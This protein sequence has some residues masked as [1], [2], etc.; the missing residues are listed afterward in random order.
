M[1]RLPPIPSARK[2]RVVGTKRRGKRPARD[3]TELTAEQWWDALFDMRRARGD[4]SMEHDRGRYKKHIKPVVD[5]HLQYVTRENCEQL[6]DHLDRQ[7]Q[8]GTM[9]WKSAKNVWAVWTTACRLACTSN[10]HVLR[11]R[12]DN[13]CSGVEAPDKG[14][15][16]SKTWLWPEEFLQLV[17]CEEVPLRWRCIYTLAIYLY[18]RGS[19][20]AA[21]R[22]GDIDWHHGI[23]HVHRSF[24]ENGK[25]KSTKSGDARRFRVETELLPLLHAMQR[26]SGGEGPLID[27]PRREFWARRL[28]EHLKLAGVTRTELFT[29]DATREHLTFH[30]LKAT[31]VTWMAIRGD[32]PLKIMQ[33][34]AHRNFQTTQTYLHAAEMVGATIGTPFPA[35]LGCILGDVTPDDDSANRPEYRLEDDNS[36]N[37]FADPQGPHPGAPPRWHS[38]RARAVPFSDHGPIRVNGRLL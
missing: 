5:T 33:R 14:I 1:R 34:A 3:G 19:E 26:E 24:D 29:D 22:W 25:A 17:T 21:L 18:L 4:S 11:V 10:K 32:E 6:R 9:A 36:L 15:A 30:D 28:R 12:R 7:I 20:L 16:R 8:T 13:P 27:M 23:A 35:L 38:P 37:L 2:Q 31:V